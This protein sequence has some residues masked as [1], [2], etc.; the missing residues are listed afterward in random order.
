ML[1]MWQSAVAS[2]AR[3]HTTSLQWAIASSP[4]MVAYCSRCRFSET[5]C[6]SV[7]SDTAFA[8]WPS[9]L[10]TRLQTVLRHC[11]P[12]SALGRLPPWTSWSK[13]LPTYCLATVVMTTS[14][15]ATPTTRLPVGRSVLNLITKN[16]V[17]VNSHQSRKPHWE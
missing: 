11:R 2:T 16:S 5:S 9:T 12:T 13:T 3:W 8:N 6:R 15:S 10:S 14:C 4:F 7:Y 1:M 17:I